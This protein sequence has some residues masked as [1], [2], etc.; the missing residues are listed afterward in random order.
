MESLVRDKLYNSF[1]NLT[2]AMLSKLYFLPSLYTTYSPWLSVLH[3]EPSYTCFH[4]R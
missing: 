1:S 3:R 4:M 2:A